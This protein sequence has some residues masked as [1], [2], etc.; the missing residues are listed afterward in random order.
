MAET[1]GIKLEV[2]ATQ[3]V[4]TL[5]ALEQKAAELNAEFKEVPMGTKRFKE[6]QQ[7]LVGVNKEIKNTELS[8]ESLDNEQV[9]SEIGS[10]A[11]AVGDMSAAFVLL[12]GDEGSIAETVQKIQMALGVSMAF[13]GAIEGLSSARKLWN[14]IIK[15]SNLFQKLNLALI[16]A[17]TV[18]QKMLGRST[19]VTSKSFKT[20][21]TAIMSTGIG[22]LVVAVGLLIANFDKIVNLFSKTSAA[23]KAANSTFD[24]FTEGMTEAIV[25]TEKVGK[26]F[27]DFHEG[28]MDAE[29]AL[30]IYNSTLG[31]SLG[32]YDDIASAEARYAATTEAFIEATALRAQAQALQQKKAELLSEKSALEHGKTI[33]A[34]DQAVNYIYSAGLGWL[35]SLEEGKVMSHSEIMKQWEDDRIA[36][37]KA[38]FKKEA[39]SYDDALKDITKQAE[40]L[41]TE[42]GIMSEADKEAKNEADRKADLA[43]RKAEKRRQER[44]RAKQAELKAIYGLELAHL[45]KVADEIDDTEIVGAEDKAKKLIEIEEFKEIELLKNKKLTATERLLIEFNTS[46]AID[47]I[48]KSV[49]D[50][51]KELEAKAIED[52]QAQW[53]LLQQIKGTQQD[54]EIAALVLEY[55]EKYALAVGNAELEK[56]L[57]IQQAEDIA[58][59]NKTY[60]DQAEE[61]AKAK[62]DKEIARKTELRD[63]TVKIA[64]DGLS[65]VANLASAFAGKSEASQRKAF[66]IN[67]SVSIAQALISTYQSA[68]SSY[69]ALAGIVPAGPVLGALA[70]AAAVASG[71]ANVKRIQKTTFDSPSPETPGQIAAPNLSGGFSPDL[72]TVTNTST[73]I[74]TGEDK[75]KVFVT[76]TDI[77]STQNQV[78][79]IEDQSTY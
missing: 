71:L 7:Q 45:Q 66:K 63:A 30:F 69:M 22:A 73:I 23:G 77:T 75:V 41:E 53:D 12:G 21:R 24:K 48:N 18:A 19:V 61:E 50:K 40:A 36:S 26:A 70:A 9:A 13:K 15:Q 56:E 49:A 25:A 39:K 34:F 46:V 29:Q 16:R 62:T 64:L 32:R 27:K 33:G 20:M 78:S 72:G 68:V 44:I 17:T 14:N 59:I 60:S 6:L 38:S 8:M 65:S 67:K 35:I 1:V 37:L 28:S 43:K 58:A 74:P 47:K 52:E 51:K 4:K 31:D 54:A 10:V 11:G 42:F 79:V 57:Q 5:G 55:E 2:D 3:G 76:E